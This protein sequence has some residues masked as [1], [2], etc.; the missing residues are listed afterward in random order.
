MN[1]NTVIQCAFCQ[2]VYY[3]YEQLAQDRDL[4][5]FMLLKEKQVNQQILED[6]NRNDFAEIYLFFDYDGHA[7]KADDNKICSLL[8]L[9]NNETESGKLYISY[10]MV[11]AYKHLH[12]EISFEQV[13]V[14]AKQ[15]I[16]YKKMV[17]NECFSDFGKNVSK[18]THENWAIILKEHLKK[19]NFIVKDSF[20]LP[21]SLI[22]Q[23]EIFNHQMKKYILPK[24]FVAVLSAFP[25]MLLEYYGLIQLNEMM[26]SNTY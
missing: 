18:F 24:N 22:T 11:E 19:M 7:T 1:E 5:L 25:P 14:Q 23:N 9:F 2:D 3:L 8:Q 4:D 26:K 15:N 10:P 20:S 16:H 6:F 21:K 13:L 12:P 17:H